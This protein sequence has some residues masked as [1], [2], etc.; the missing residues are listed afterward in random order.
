M[1]TFFRMPN[2][3]NVVIRM[4]DND[5]T[6]ILCGDEDCTVLSSPF[7]SFAL[8]ENVL[9]IIARFVVVAKQPIKETYISSSSSVRIEPHYH[10]DLQKNKRLSEGD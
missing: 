5:L 3:R 8:G 10:K 4:V 2:R 7:S 6:W 1:R 9:F